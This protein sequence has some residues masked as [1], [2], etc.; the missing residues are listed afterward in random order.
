MVLQGVRYVPKPK[1]NLI[2]ISSF[3]LIG[4]S[5]K[6]ENGIMKVSTRDSI[7]AKGRKSNGLYIL[8]GSTVIAHASGASQTIEDKTRLWHL[9]MSHI[10]EKDL[11]ELEKQNRLMRDK[12][13]K[14]D[15][16]DHCVLGKSHKVKFGTD[17]H[18]STRPFEYAHADLWGS[19][20][21]QNHGG[22]T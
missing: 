18:T 15:F 2:S 14:M 8:E 20:R 13:Q 17:K 3:N 10:S 1:R 19:S 11:K 6:V 5:M 7:V 12:L 22:G 16:Y 9:R 4:Y 21:T